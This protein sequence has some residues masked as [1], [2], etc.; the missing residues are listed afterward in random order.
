MSLLV[1]SLA[2]LGFDLSVQSTEADWACLAGADVGGTFGIVRLYRNLGEVDRNATKSIL[3]ANTAISNID[4]YMFPCVSQSQYSID[5]NITCTDAATQVK[6]TLEFLAEEGIGVKG[7]TYQ[8]TPFFPLLATLGRVWIDIEDEVPSK[9]YSANHDDNIQFIADLTTSLRGLG[10]EVGIYSTK[11]YWQN[12]M[13][14]VHGY[15]QYKLW[16]PRYD[17]INSMDFASSVMPFADFTEV[18]IKQTNGD[19]GACGISQVDSN[20]ME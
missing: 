3:A 2:S 9:Y 17:A 5:H 16:Y 7:S 19:V 13:N 15:G 10:I 20:Y 8:P 14:N 4:G 11:S 12:I 6:R 1:A 18:Y